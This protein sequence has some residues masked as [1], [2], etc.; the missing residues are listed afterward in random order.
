VQVIAASRRL[1]S[2]QSLN[3]TRFAEQA[4]TDLD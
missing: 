3:A 2:G 4:C 1:V